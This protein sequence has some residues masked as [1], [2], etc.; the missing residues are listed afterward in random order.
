MSRTIVF[1]H[2]AWVTAACW[3]RMLPWFEAR[4]YRCMAP[5]WPGKDRAI[6]A[7]RADPSALKGL[8]IARIVDHYESVIRSLDDPEPPIL[9]GHSFGGLF[10]QILLDRGLG[11]AG[12]AIDSAPPKGVWPFEPSAFRAL[13]GALLRSALGRRVVR[14]SFDEFRYGFVHTLPLEEARAAYDRQVVPETGRIFFEGAMAPIDPRSPARVN[15]ANETRAPLLLI[16][17]EKDHVVPPVVNRRNHRAYRRSPARTD[18]REFP[19][20]VH[21]ILAEDG[22]QEVAEHIASWLEEL[23]MGPGPPPRSV[24]SAA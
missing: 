2:G 9:V 24:S 14:W 10:T 15:F 19:R 23:G 20:R 11:A 5:A 16:A 1:L 12:V 17:G 18:Y 13:A 21:W 22:W 6:E 3:E 4:G 8:G 7:I